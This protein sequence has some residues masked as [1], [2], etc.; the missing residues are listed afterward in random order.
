MSPDYSMFLES[1]SVRKPAGDLL[2]CENIPGTVSLF[3][4]FS[5][6]RW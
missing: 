1:F 4:I 6:F 5:I 3:Q 2:L